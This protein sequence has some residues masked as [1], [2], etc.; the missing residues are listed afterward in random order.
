MV[1]WAAHRLPPGRDH[2]AQAG[3]VLEVERRFGVVG[4]IAQHV[5]VLLTTPS[6]RPTTFLPRAAFLSQLAI[7]GVGGQQLGV[8]IG[9]DLRRSRRPSISKWR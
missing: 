9:G 6:R 2:R 8:R 7:G 4:I 5:G 3:R 1:R